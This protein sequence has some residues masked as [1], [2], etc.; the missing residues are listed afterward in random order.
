MPILRLEFPRPHPAQG[1]VIAEAKRFNVLC[2]GRR[3]GKTELGM[4]RVCRTAL[5]GGKAGWFAPTYKYS[6]PVYRELESRLHTA[7]TSSN[8]TDG[9][10]RLVTGG[11]IEVWTLDSPDAGR[12]RAYKLI[13]VDEAAMIAKMR[14][15]WQQALR[16]TLADYQ[17]DAWF[18]STPKGIASAFHEFFQRGQDP[19]QPDWASWHMPTSTNPHIV[20]SEIESARQDMTDLAFAQEYLAE[21]VSW[22]GAV[23]RRIRDA[24]MAEAVLNIPAVVIGVDWGRTNDYTVFTALSATGHVL[25]LDRFRGMEYALQRM[26]LAEFWRKHG[27]RS[28]IVAEANSMGGPVIEQLQRDGLPVH[29]FVTTS[30]SKSAIIEALA[31][32]FERAIIHIPED[33]VLIGELQAF[34]GQPSPSGMVRYAAPEGMHDDTVMSLAIAWSGLCVRRDTEMERLTGVERQGFRPRGISPI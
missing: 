16:P 12:S 32:A 17:G 9:M 3:W 5:A 15:A 1:R 23:F 8:K 13:V 27:S 21:F 10:L 6:A 11:E 29:A 30:A 34:E 22:E 24:V 20:T 28:V 33:I 14:D 4:D 26:R 31:L 25:G 7:L 2:C 19:L 18:L